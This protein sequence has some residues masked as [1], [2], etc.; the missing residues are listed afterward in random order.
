MQ[1]ISTQA[2]LAKL[3][4]NE[5]Q[6]RFYGATCIIARL[7]GWKAYKSQGTPLIILLKEVWISLII[8]IFGGNLQKMWVHGR[9]QTRKSA[10]LTMNSF[11]L[12]NHMISTFV[13]PLP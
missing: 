7:G 2:K 1:T 9:L 12:K 8:F 13:A 11:H 3:K 6:L 4:K 10:R 5:A